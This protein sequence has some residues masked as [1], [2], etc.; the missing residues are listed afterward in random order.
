M[1]LA[2]AEME[3]RY[4][5]ERSGAAYVKPSTLLLADERVLEAL[6]PSSDDAKIV[7]WALAQLP[8]DPTN[9]GGSGAVWEKIIDLITDDDDVCSICGASEDCDCDDGDEA[10]RARERQPVPPVP[11]GYPTD[12]ALLFEHIGD[13]LISID[14]RDCEMLICQKGEMEGVILT[15][16]FA[17]ALAHFLNQPDM[18]E[19]VAYHRGLANCTAPLNS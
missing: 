11:A 7:D 5:A 6:D 8:A 16:A 15:P 19:L 13:I 3:A 17:L 2:Q 4:D 9:D 1:T 12:K 14:R 18:R 10:E